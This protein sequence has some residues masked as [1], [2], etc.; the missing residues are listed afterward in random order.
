MLI[1]I[2]KID[3]QIR[4]LQKLKTLLEDPEMASLL[5]ELVADTE[6][7]PNSSSRGDLMKAVQ[8][9]VTQFKGK[10]RRSDVIAHMQ[11]FNFQ[12][13]DFSNVN[14]PLRKLVKK[15]IIC[16]CVKGSGR[17]GHQYE[18]IQDKNNV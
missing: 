18:M 2:L 6:H 4:K 7:K 12:F 14:G 5:D 16:I 9:A 11:K 17:R 8:I 10:F 1:D 15:D 13:T 3:R